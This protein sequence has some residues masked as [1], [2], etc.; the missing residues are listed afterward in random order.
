MR[1]KKARNSGKKGWEEGIKGIRKLRDRG[2][3]QPKGK[4]GKERLS[5]K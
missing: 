4:S 5:E 3:K 1:E 2:S